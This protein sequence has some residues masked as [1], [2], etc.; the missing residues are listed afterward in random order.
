M[1]EPTRA[2]P[3]LRRDAAA[4]LGARRDLGPDYEDAVAASLADRVE[5]LVAQ[6]TAEVRP[7]SQ[8]RQH[9]REEEKATGDGRFVIALASLGAGIPITGIVHDSVV[10]TAIAWAGIVGINVAAALRGRRPR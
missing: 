2:T 5:E 7:S 1:S 6:R 3:E 4:A 9:D 10:T 8:D